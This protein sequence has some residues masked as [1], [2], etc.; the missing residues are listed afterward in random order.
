ML[1][2]RQA[3]AGMSHLAWQQKIG[4]SGNIEAYIGLVNS[5]I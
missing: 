1:K 2:I 5:N 4:N 3:I